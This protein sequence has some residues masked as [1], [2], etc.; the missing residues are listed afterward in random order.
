MWLCAAKITKFSDGRLF[1]SQAIGKVQLFNST[2]M[3]VGNINHH[4]EQTA[5]P[6][7]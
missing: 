1:G 5:N 3:A 2:D 6:H 7:Q 4:K